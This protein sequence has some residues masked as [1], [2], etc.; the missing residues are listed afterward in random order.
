MR[1]QNPFKK[2]KYQNIYNF[3]NA[4][5]GGFIFFLGAISDGNVTAKGVL[6][7]LIVSFSIVAVKF[8]EYWD[9]EKAE[10]SAKVLNFI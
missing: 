4:F 9:S 1:K 6:G 10:Y 2:N 8:K 5:L 7:A 3:I